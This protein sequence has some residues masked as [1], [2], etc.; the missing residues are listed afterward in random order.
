MFRRRRD[1]TISFTVSL[2]SWAVCLGSRLPAIVRGMRKKYQEC[3]VCLMSV[4][5]ELGTANNTW[6]G[7]VRKRLDVL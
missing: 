5:G 1:N 2:Y 7:P 6:L 4:S 3:I